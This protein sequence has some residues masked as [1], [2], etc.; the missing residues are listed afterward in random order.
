[1]E[2]EKEL[3]HAVFGVY[4]GHNIENYMGEVV[5]YTGD[6]IQTIEVNGNT[7]VEETLNLPEGEYYYQE[8][9][10]EQYYTKDENKYDFKIDYS[11]DIETVEVKEQM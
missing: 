11:K 10:A 3:Q 1:M 4:A 6:L 5:I 9:F 2:N 8:I 7:T